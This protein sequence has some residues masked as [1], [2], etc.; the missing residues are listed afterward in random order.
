MGAEPAR[1]AAE[2][3]AVRFRPPMLVSLGF[4]GAAAPEL[5]VGDVFV[6]LRVVSE[7]GVDV[8]VTNAERAHGILVTASR[9]SGPKAKRELRAR[10]GADAVDMEAAAVARVA[11]DRDLAFFAVKAISDGPELTMPPFERFVCADGRFDIAAFVVFAVLRPRLWL[12]LA[13]LS[14]N[15][16]V[17]SATLARWLSQYNETLPSAEAAQKEFAKDR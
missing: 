2:A 15:A 12:A 1:Q 7:T 11:A 4:A 6:P 14:R 10:F 16:S 8:F 3:L 9:V 13:R 17:A 5:R